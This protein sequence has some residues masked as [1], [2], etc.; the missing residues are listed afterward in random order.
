MDMSG[1]RIT[2]AMALYRAEVENKQLRQAVLFWRSHKQ[3]KPTVV[4]HKAS[5]TGESCD[6]EEVI[7]ISNKRQKV[8]KKDLED[9]DKRTK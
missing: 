9:A 3:A 7:T 8:D 1:Q 2:L 5:Q 6:V 4:V